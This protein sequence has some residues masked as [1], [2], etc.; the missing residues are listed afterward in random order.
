VLETSTSPSLASAATQAPIWT[1]I[2]AS[3]SPATSHSPVWTPARI[4]SPSSRTAAI[5]APP[6]RIARAG[7]SKLARN[8][9]GSVDLTAAETLELTP[10]R[11]MV[12]VEEL[13]PAPVADL[14]CAFGR[15]DNV[16]EQHGRE[17]AVG[18]VRLAHSGQELPDLVEDLVAFDARPRDMGPAG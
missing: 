2:P 12:R 8:I 13:T 16:R 11:G 3:R 1:A 18:L 10:H 17:H 5:A 7:P 14:A 15:A 6:Q 4:S 9:S